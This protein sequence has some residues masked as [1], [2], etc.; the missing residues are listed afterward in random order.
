MFKLPKRVTIYKVRIVYK[1]GYFHDFEETRRNT[2]EHP[3]EKKR[4]K[5][6]T[7]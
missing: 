3:D 1:S 4:P 5:R 2:P 6:R 7:R